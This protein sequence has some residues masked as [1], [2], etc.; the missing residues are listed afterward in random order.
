MT[1]R[2][3]TPESPCSNNLLAH[4]RGGGLRRESP[5]SRSRIPT[6]EREILTCEE[7]IAAYD[8]RT[9][10]LIRS[11]KVTIYKLKKYKMFR[12]CSHE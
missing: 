9:D 5:H 12:R 7:Y 4:K 6:Q 2:S 10:P 11:P 1:R 8:C 3:S